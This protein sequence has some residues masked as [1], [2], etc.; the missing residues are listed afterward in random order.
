MSAAPAQDRASLLVIVPCGQRKIWDSCPGAGATPA[1]SAYTGPLFVVNRRFAQTFADRWVILSAKY[2][3]I[4]PGFLIPEAYNV[5]FK[6]RSTHPVEAEVLRAQAAK[7][8]LESYGEVIGLGGVEYR[9]MVRE[10]FRESGATL[11]FPFAGLPL[12]ASMA[13]VNQA[14][15]ARQIPSSRDPGRD[16]AVST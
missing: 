14:V 11:R 13:A 16:G 3:F 12:G 1:E 7:M 15:A 9:K 2:G 4:D 6:R 8:D 5:T 10:A